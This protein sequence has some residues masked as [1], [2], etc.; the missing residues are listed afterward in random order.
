MVIFTFIIVVWSGVDVVVATLLARARFRRLSHA[1]Q[2]ERERGECECRSGAIDR[3]WQFTG[4]EFSLACI[5]HRSATSV[6]NHGL[7]HARR[8]RRC[9][10][11]RVRFHCYAHCATACHSTV[12]VQCHRRP[13]RR[14]YR[15][16]APTT[17]GR[18]PTDRRC[19]PFRLQHTNARHRSSFQRSISTSAWLPSRTAPY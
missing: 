9:T 5:H 11:V 15:P 7:V 17:G 10:D 1:V 3:Q 13:E 19:H 2:R 12:A 14:W 16:N 18:V 4:F 8:H 6:A